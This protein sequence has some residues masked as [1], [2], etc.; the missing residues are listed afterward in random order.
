MPPDAL[1]SR[2]LE[3]FAA[4]RALRAGSFIV[5]IYGDVVGPR[6]GPVWMG[7]LIETCRLVGVSESLA[8]TAVSRLVEAGRLRGSREGRRSFYHL[9]PAAEAEFD[10]AA[11]ALHGAGAAAEDEPWTLAL[12]P[13]AAP[14]GAMEALAR[15]GFGLAGGFALKPGEAGPEARAALGG[16]AVIF[17]GP[18]QAGS[19]GLAALAASAWDLDALSAAYAGFRRRF[20]PLAAALDEEA[21]CD[22]AA[23]ALRL[24]LVHDFRH[25]ALR[26]PGLPVSALPP[27]WEGAAARALFRGLH[28]ALTPAAGRR[29]RATVLGRDGPLP[30]EDAA[31]RREDA[32]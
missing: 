18:P 11:R 28:A 7:S 8:R 10:A 16:G 30:A 25:I 24:L 2:L 9:T 1:L 32:A 22:A 21:P 4:R 26:D 12:A 14:P 29:V 20:A 6:G 17:R 27:G 19:G 3:D 31:A 5:T 13:A 15:R 23:L